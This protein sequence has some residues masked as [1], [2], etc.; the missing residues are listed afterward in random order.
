MKL[1]KRIG[2]C[3]CDMLM[4]LQLAVERKGDSILEP[5]PKP[6]SRAHANFDG[7]RVF[8]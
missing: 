4:D 1:C 3:G 2:D 5:V 7:G 6:K 8:E